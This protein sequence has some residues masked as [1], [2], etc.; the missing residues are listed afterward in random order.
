[1]FFELGV[2]VPQGATT[3]APPAREEIEKLLEIAPRFGIEIRLP[4][5]G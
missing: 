3:A 1:M 5:Y 4:R 2:P